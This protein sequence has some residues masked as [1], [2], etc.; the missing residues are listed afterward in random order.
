MNHDSYPPIGGSDGL[1]I[2]G[3]FCLVMKHRHFLDGSCIVEKETRMH[4][5]IL[6]RP[7]EDL[8]KND[9]LEGNDGVFPACSFRLVERAARQQRLD[10]ARQLFQRALA[11]GNDL[12][13]SAE[14]YDA[15]AAEM[16]GDFPQA[17]TR[18]SLITA[19]V[20]VS[21]M[22]KDKA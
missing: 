20:N 15:S 6:Y 19:I 16:L 12:G 2:S 18:L 9:E 4:L 7:P 8:P 5:P 21:E 11:T 22:A 14:Q 3:D 17:P 10:E 1:L 13:L